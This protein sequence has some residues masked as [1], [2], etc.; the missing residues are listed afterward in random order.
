MLGIFAL[1]V[2]SVQGALMVMIGHGLST[3]ALFLL[4]GMIYER[5]HTRLID[6]YGGIAKVVPLFATI[7]TIVALS[8]IGL[9]GTNGF[10]AEFL[11][12]VGAFRTYPVLTLFSA[13]GVIL[14]AAYLLWALQRMIYNK[15]D[16]PQNAALRDLNW[17]ELGLLVPI[18]AGILWMGVYPKP[19]LDRMEASARRFVQ[20]VGGTSATQ[21]S[22]PGAGR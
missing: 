10:V 16:K 13:T 2:E 22:T 3:G 6:Q 21:A 19:V 4:V 15:L 20:T 5:T 18:L 1:T 8:S 9:P 7:L 17:R 14:A 12:M 11:V